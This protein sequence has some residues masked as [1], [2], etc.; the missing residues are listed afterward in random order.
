MSASL[1]HNNTLYNNNN[2]T[3]N[4]NNQ[5]NTNVTHNQPNN[6]LS[7]LNGITISR[8]AILPSL[9]REDT[10]SSHLPQYTRVS[11]NSTVIQQ[12]MVN[13]LSLT[14]QSS[15]N[16]HTAN[17]LHT[18]QSDT[19]ITPIHNPSSNGDRTCHN[20]SD[21]N[22]Q[23]IHTSRIPSVDITASHHIHHARKP[24]SLA[25]AV[26]ELMGKQFLSQ[27][28]TINDTV[29]DQGNTMNQSHHHHDQHHDNNMSYT[30]EQHNSNLDSFRSNKRMSKHKR[31]KPRRSTSNKLLK[32][33]KSTFG[34]LFS[35]PQSNSLLRNNSLSRQSTST[36]YLSQE[37]TE[38]TLFLFWPDG[39]IRQYCI[40]LASSKYYVNFNLFIILCNCVTMGLASGHISSESYGFASQATALNTFD[41]SF[42]IIFTIELCVKCIAGGFIFAGP[43]SY[44]KS[45]WNIIDFI[46]VVF[47]LLTFIPSFNNFTYIRTLRLLRPLKAATN[48]PGL[49][50]MM[51]AMFQSV[52]ALG[53]VALF[54]FILLYTFGM[55]GLQ[56]WRDQY[57]YRC[58]PIGTPVPMFCNNP[59]DCNS[60]YGFA[61][62]SMT[63]GT[64]PG[65]SARACPS[66]YECVNVY[67]APYGGASA[68]DNIIQSWLMSVIVMSGEGWSDFMFLSEDSVSRA[69]LWYFLIL[70]AAS[71]YIG[72]SLIEAV[73]SVRFEHAKDEEK[74]RL[75]KE[76]KQALLM[77]KMTQAM[78]V[79]RFVRQN[80]NNKL[81]SAQQPVVNELSDDSFSDSEEESSDIEANYNNNN[82]TTMN[83]NHTKSHHTRQS[84]QL[85]EFMRLHSLSGKVSE[86]GIARAVQRAARIFMKYKDIA[87][88]RKQLQKLS[89][90]EELVR[91]QASRPQTAKSRGDSELTRNALLRMHT[92]QLD[93]LHSTNTSKTQSGQVTPGHL[94]H[95][96]TS[97]DVNKLKQLSRIANDNIE[98]YLDLKHQHRRRQH[99][100]NTQNPSR[101]TA[102]HLID[103]CVDSWLLIRTVCCRIALSQWAERVGQI[104]T[105]INL[106]TL[107]IYSW[108]MPYW[109]YHTCETIQLVLTICLTI[110]FVFR[111]VGFG[112]KRYFT[113]GYNIFDF[114]VV[115]IGYLD[116]FTSNGQL[117]ALQA[118]RMIRMFTIFRHYRPLR[119][120]LDKIYMSL[121]DLFY[122]GLLYIMFV[123]IFA[124]LGV[125]IAQNAMQSLPQGPG[126]D[127]FDNL[128][129]ACITVFQTTTPENWNQIIYDLHQSIG[130][131]AVVYIVCTYLIG[132]YVIE[133]LF[134][135]VMLSDFAMTDDEKDN[136]NYRMDQLSA[137]GNSND[138]SVI[139]SQTV[140]LIR[141]SSHK[142]IS[143]LTSNDMMVNNIQS[144]DTD[145]NNNDVIAVIP[146]DQDM[147]QSTSTA[148][149]PQLI[150]TQSNQRHSQGRGFLAGITSIHDNRLINRIRA[151]VAESNHRVLN[152]R[153]NEI[154]L[155]NTVQHSSHE[156]RN[157]AGVD[158]DNPL[159][160][161]I[162][163]V[164]NKLHDVAT[165]VGLNRPSSG[166]THKR[167]NSKLLSSRRHTLNELNIDT[168]GLHRPNDSLFIDPYTMNDDMLPMSPVTELLD[169]PISPVQQRRRTWAPNRLRDNTAQN[170]VS[171][172]DDTIQPTDQSSHTTI[173]TDQLI[174]NALQSLK[175]T[176]VSPVPITDTITATSTSRTINMLHRRT[177]TPPH[178]TPSINNDTNSITTH[179]PKITILH[180]PNRH[181]GALSIASLQQP[182]PAQSP[183]HTPNKKSTLVIL[184]NNTNSAS[185]DQTN[186]QHSITLDTMDTATT[187][188]VPQTLSSSGNK[189]YIKLF[190]PP[191]SPQPL[192]SPSSEPEL[193]SM[194]VSNNN[195]STPLLT[196]QLQHITD[197]NT[198]LQSPSRASIQRTSTLNQSQLH[199]SNTITDISSTADKRAAF[200]R[201]SSLRRMPSHRNDGAYDDTTTLVSLTQSIVQSRKFVRQRSRARFTGSGLDLGNTIDFKSKKNKFLKGM[202]KLFTNK[203]K[204][205]N[206]VIPHHYRH[207]IKWFHAAPAEPM[208]YRSLFLFSNTHPI[209]QRLSD[210]IYSNAMNIG[211]VC[212][213]ITSCVILALDSVAMQ[214]Y[215][216]LISSI[217]YLD[218]ITTGLYVVEMCMRIVVMGLILHP[219][220]YLRN[221]W[222]SLE[223]IIIIVSLVSYAYP[224]IQTLKA[225]RALRPLR[226][227]SRVR[228]ARVVVVSLYKSMQTMFNVFV[229]SLILFLMLSVVAV[230]LFQGRLQSCVSVS[231]YQTIDVAIQCCGTQD[232]ACCVQDPAL[233]T[234]CNY[235]D[236][237]WT[238]PLGL[239]NYDNIGNALLAMFELT[240]E[241][242]WPTLMY[243][244]VDSTSYGEPPIMNN[245][246][247]YGIFFVCA[248]IINSL[249]IKNLFTATILD[250]YSKYYA[251]I[252]GTGTECVNQVQSQWLDFYKLCVD[253]PP[254]DRV[255]RPQTQWLSKYDL[256]FR[257][258]M[259]DV[260]KSA[261]CQKLFLCVIA[262]NVV[263]LSMPYGNQSSN[264]SNAIM[265]VNWWCTWVYVIELL[266]IWFANG[267]KQ[268]FRHTYNCIDF[269]VVIS[270]VIEFLSD[271]NIIS[272]SSIGIH[273]SLFRVIRLTRIFK[274]FIQFPTL[275]QLG[276]TLWF[277]LPALQNV[278]ML[279]FLLFFIYSIA[280]MN[281]FG[282][283]QATN[284]LTRHR[285]FSS[286]TS[287]MVTLFTMVTGESWNGI[288]R[289]CMIQPPFCSTELD[290]CGS[291]IAAPLLFVSFMVFSS[292]L[293]VELV[294][295]VILNQ[296][297]NELEKEDRLGRAFATENDI[298]QFGELWNKYTHTHTMGVLRLTAFIRDIEL[299]RSFDPK[300]QFYKLNNVEI[301]TVIDSLNIPCN[302][303]N[304]VHYL[305]VIH[306]LGE[307][308][309]Y[310]AYPEALDM[311]TSSNTVTRTNT[312]QTNRNDMTVTDEHSTATGISDTPLPDSRTQ[313]PRGISR[314]HSISTN[315]K[316]CTTAGIRLMNDDL[317]LI[318]QQAH[319][320]FPCFTD[321]TRFIS[322]AGE[323]NRVMMLQKVIRGFIIRKR[324][325]SIKRTSTQF[326]RQ[327]STESNASVLL[328]SNVASIDKSAVSGKRSTMID[329]TNQLVTP[330]NTFN[331][332][333]M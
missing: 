285:N 259:Y 81:Q 143:E 246:Q 33:S 188:H 51:Y 65:F 324:Y 164:S 9:D 123:F 64:L 224:S 159:D 59:P 148:P 132:H 231:T 329:L 176:Q 179:N 114:I 274:L 66:G 32:R 50:V 228:S 90:I 316:Q 241:E 198:Q 186:A 200:I 122:M 131:G 69:S 178:I 111:L 14:R 214:P 127:N 235:N 92:Q 141:Q 120:L 196:S 146:A 277:S 56:I 140:P 108:D 107:C 189:H 208:I 49:R 133:T 276:N 194:S 216:T 184:R 88:Q 236:G 48:I 62:C 129:W 278:A 199:R 258:L 165:A 116:I 217:Y 317:I 197:D 102:L 163:S 76:K 79:S 210:M 71:N 239:P 237:I 152:D 147:I 205:I 227:L 312:Q 103:Y 275:V 18:F 125:Q 110:E 57:I 169:E 172:S 262:L 293:I 280:A 315:N 35:G 160:Q 167:T 36:Y 16:I 130:W 242:N 21:T 61:A 13:D 7:V 222:N 230:Q 304:H 251:E 248:I 223:C 253:H 203:P 1:Q 144:N 153:D 113:N 310:M 314:A 279:L 295:A 149:I 70:T 54:I 291:P 47:A 89:E 42:S 307:R 134:V 182:T 311:Y 118:L 38:R 305:D 119:I 325:R 95:S 257:R 126:R 138:K 154:S 245:T 83:I 117:R 93:K 157:I 207:L 243:S 4:N 43:S 244:A 229:V 142:N 333:S 15:T 30:N 321:Q 204:G 255:L 284:Y 180:S 23:P 286:W 271:I 320:S 28:N 3:N 170:I 263:V 219:G 12:H 193:L 34:M 174:A 191:T 254:T 105:I 192:L 206:S 115:M 168:A 161:W 106:I 37:M 318:R 112:F 183:Q 31:S 301:G 8:N 267:I 332:R 289:D 269:L 215:T 328:D 82:N 104:W 137:N 322:F 74:Q 298:I 5:H 220:A 270:C 202:K 195:S 17:R 96:A 177:P 85:P 292:M 156:G 250:G 264:Y 213:I 2:N 77:K 232:P 145:N 181:T 162:F 249:F 268:Y 40:Q 67:M 60:I 308:A 266:L 39:I 24:S 247:A 303:D 99:R 283:V 313:T 327:K 288:M 218:F 234:V 135:V 75:L 331:R 139:Q 330:K 124:Q 73:M 273:S 294:L 45:S 63:P 212:L 86:L 306:Q 101:H 302:D 136:I 58:T 225:L 282:R 296:F 171:P 44:L 20:S 84:S 252:T 185:I 97:N 98:A 290:T 240:T 91:E 11:S 53:N 281:L 190:S 78:S 52:K 201:K 94:I 226:F 175:N 187:P 158:A 287:S 26:H 238:N 309:F 46:V 297:S 265:Y 100:Y 109:L 10:P 19:T 87:Y 166:T 300:R 25:D 233:G 121:E 6:R 155:R 22:N 72:G 128:G 256:Y 55:I 319:R 27:L 173:D 211:V 29:D 323:C 41:A 272:I 151:N 221:S 150:A 209:R 299:P 261:Q 326:S 80:N 68:Y 260:S